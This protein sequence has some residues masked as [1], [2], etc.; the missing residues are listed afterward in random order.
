MGNN[1]LQTVP[2]GVLQL[3]K[4]TLLELENNKIPKQEIAKLQKS[5]PKCEVIFE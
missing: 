5:L 1:L 3:E 4:L 2:L